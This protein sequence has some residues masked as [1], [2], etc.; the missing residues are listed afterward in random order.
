[1]LGISK[2]E[3]TKIPQALKDVAEAFKKAAEKATARNKEKSEE[4]KRVAKTEE[5]IV[6]V[7]RL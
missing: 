1:M 5:K 6:V 7:A 2:V 3:N 4:A